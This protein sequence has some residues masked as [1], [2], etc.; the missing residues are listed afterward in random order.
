[1]DSISCTSQSERIIIDYLNKSA[2][3]ILFRM[4]QFPKVLAVFF[5]QQ[6]SGQYYYGTVRRFIRQEA[7]KCLS[8]EFTV[9]L[10]CENYPQ[11]FIS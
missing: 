8:P 2:D 1:M 10:I 9:Q 3:F 4:G 6:T 5:Y 11:L 7:L